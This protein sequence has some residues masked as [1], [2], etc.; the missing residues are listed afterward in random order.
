MCE[1]ISS[2]TLAPLYYY[3]N[4][5]S[6]DDATETYNYL[7]NLPFVSGSVKLYGKEFTERRLTYACGDIKYHKYSG[8]I[9]EMNRWDNKVLEVKEKISNISNNIYNS[10][11][12]NWYRDGTDI[13]SMHSDKEI[14]NNMGDVY[15]TVSTLS[16]GATRKFRI[17]SKVKVND[18]FEKIDINLNNGDLI[19]MGPHFQ[20]YYTHGIPQQKKVMEGRISLT[21]RYMDN[22]I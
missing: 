5:L 19:I 17:K 6:N 20:D 1:Q 22:N 4:F 7:T 2:L 15:S 8:K 16:L 3:K 9:M 14:V 13:I 21:F 11:L 10:S 12:L 18:M